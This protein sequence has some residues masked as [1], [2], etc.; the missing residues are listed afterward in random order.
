MKLLLAYAGADLQSQGESFYR[1]AYAR[2]VAEPL[3]Y[4][5][6]RHK[7]KTFAAIACAP[8]RGLWPKFLLRNSPYSP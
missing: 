7:N 2:R 8:V 5:E 6:E 4:S 1:S 3:H